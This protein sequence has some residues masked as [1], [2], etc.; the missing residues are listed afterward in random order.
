M[1]QPTVLILMPDLAKVSGSFALK[2]LN[3]VAAGVRSQQA[4]ARTMPQNAVLNTLEG[5][6]T[7]SGSFALAGL[8]SNALSVRSQHAF[9]FVEPHILQPFGPAYPI[10]RTSG[11][12]VQEYS[13]VSRNAS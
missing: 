2:G 11:K 7:L 4:S 10:K 6:A 3:S 8:A 9:A 12:L 5:L 1:S 13:V